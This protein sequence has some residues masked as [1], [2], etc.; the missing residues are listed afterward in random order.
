[1]LLIDVPI[2]I[3]KQLKDLLWTVMEQHPYSPDLSPCD[4]EMFGLVKEELGGRNEKITHPMEQM[5]C[6]IRKLCRKI[7]HNCICYK[8]VQSILK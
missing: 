2:Q 3:G 6:K 7:R 4:Y 5:C 1:M 8:T